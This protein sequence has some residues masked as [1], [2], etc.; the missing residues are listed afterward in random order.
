MQEMSSNESELSIP[1][2]LARFWPRFLLFPVLAVV[3]YPPFVLGWGGDSFLVRAAWVLF[4]TFCWFC[5]GGA[6]HEAVHQTMF[7][8][9]SW[10]VWYGRLLGALSLIPYTIYRETH[11][12]H[13]AYLNTPDDY[14][15]WPYSDPRRSLAFRRMFVWVDLLLGVL[16]GPFLYSRIYF[17]GDP[18]L[19]P[20]I[21]RTVGRE[22]IGLAAFWGVLLASLG[23]WGTLRGFDWWQFDPVWLLPLLLAPAFNTARKFVEHLGM[24]SKDPILGTRTIVARNPATR[25]A[26]YFNF[27]IAVHGPHHRFPRVQHYELAPKLATYVQSNP[28]APVQVF[29]S[30][31]AAT[32]D[33]LPCL[34]RNPATGD[35]GA[36]ASPSN[37]GSP[38]DFEAAVVT[39]TQP[40]TRVSPGPG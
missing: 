35:H 13:H 1:S 14:E 22:Y 33:M 20:E 31:L 32:V 30:Y 21:R 27:D 16:A 19:K 11:R 10:N 37:V 17:S 9:V 8:R 3:L 12:W 34:W 24:T 26:C 39:L 36:G 28:D 38:E 18:R 5:I 15:L 29:G 7:R 6:F 23:I 25:L 4:L 40:V 2:P